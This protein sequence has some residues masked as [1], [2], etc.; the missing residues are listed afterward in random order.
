MDSD[1]LRSP[2]LLSNDYRGPFPGGG[3]GVKLTTRLKLVPRSRI[4]YLYVHYPVRLHGEVLNYL[5]TRT[6]LLFYFEKL[7]L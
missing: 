6:T 4:V 5:R 7:I 2:S 1:G 3:T